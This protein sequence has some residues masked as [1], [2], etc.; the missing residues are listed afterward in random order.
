MLMTIR[1][2]RSMNADD[3]V[4]VEGLLNSMGVEEQI[5]RLV[6]L[7]EHFGP[8]EFMTAHDRLTTRGY[9]FDEGFANWF[10]ELGEL[11]E[12]LVQRWIDAKFEELCQHHSARAQI[13]GQFA[14][15]AATVCSDVH[16]GTKNSRRDGF[17]RWLSEQVNRKIILM[18]DIL[19]LWIYSSTQT[20]AE[21]ATWVAAHW[22]ELWETLAKARDR[23]CSIHFIPGNH[24]GFAYFIE[25]CQSG[26]PWSTSIVSKAPILTAILKETTEYRLVDVADI[27]YPFLK[28]RMGSQHILL[29]H[30]HFASLG[31]R[32]TI[33]LEDVEIPAWLSSMS[34]VLA[35]K[36]ARI[37]RRLNNEKDWLVRTHRIEDTA[38]AITNAILVAYEGAAA[39]LEKDPGGTVDLINDA[40]AL[41]FGEG[42]VTAPETEVA[43]IREAF[44]FMQLA[45]RDYRLGLEEVRSQ[46]QKLLQQS[47]SNVSLSKVG[48]SVIRTLRPF[49][50][51]QNFD[52]LVFGHFHNPRGTV[53]IF[54]SGGYVDH[55]ETSLDIRGRGI[56][57]RGTNVL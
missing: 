27:H 50:E 54:D 9:I 51:F 14:R 26:D 53:D 10:A 40:M 18:G 5:E 35:H 13:E 20:D 36:N 41:Y 32:L 22:I 38:L 52:T 56:V 28:L 19:D 16:L 37:L 47:T 39:K 34:I 42:G 29:T 46:H 48:G 7:R 30:G 6:H 43:K 25:S 31:W 44:L 17:Y 15:I 45:P 55:V 24:D 12:G 57:E 2:G 11:D 21:L 3:F 23:G 33:G 8:H 49:S 4:Y 1:R